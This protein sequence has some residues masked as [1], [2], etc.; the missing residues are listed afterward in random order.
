MT[1]LIDRAGDALETFSQVAAGIEA[2]VDH[3]TKRLVPVLDELA[4]T[5]EEIRQLTRLAR[6]GE[7]T[8]G[9]LLNNP[10]LYRSLT[11][12]VTRLERVLS[13]V[14]LL[15]QEIRTEGLTLKR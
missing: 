3:L 7:G 15:T 13:E 10:D 2:D 14:Q 1:A 6:Q 8:I 12:A 11:D 4:T 9:Q 5:L